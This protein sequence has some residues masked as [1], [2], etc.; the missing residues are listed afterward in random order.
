MTKTT[1]LSEKLVLE[2]QKKKKQK[3]FAEANKSEAEIPMLQI[4]GVLMN[5]EESLHYLKL[6]LEAY[7]R[8]KMEQQD[9]KLIC[10]TCGYSSL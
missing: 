8:A 7:E 4:D 3:L 2:N 1:S 9:V 10:P 5:P 6:R